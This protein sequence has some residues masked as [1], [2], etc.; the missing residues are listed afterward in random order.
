M[1]NNEN[2]TSSAAAPDNAGNANTPKKKEKK[3]KP[4]G[5]FKTMMASML[6]FILATVIMCVLFIVCTIGLL[7]HI[8]NE[9]TTKP[10]KITTES[11]LTLDLT[12]AISDRT[13]DELQSYFNNQEN[14]IGLCD[15]LLALDDAKNNNQI[16]GLFLYFGEGG[17]VNWSQSDEL[18]QSVRAFR[19]S[20]KPVVAYG[21]SYSQ[22]SYHLATAA[23]KIYL[24]PAGVIDLRGI[25]MESIYLKDLLEKYDIHVDLIRPNSNAFKSAGEMY[26]RNNMSDD[27]R[28]QNRAY[29]MRIWQIASDQMAN[30]RNMTGDSL[31]HIAANLEGFLANEAWQHGLVDS[32]EFER[33]ARQALSELCGTNKSTGI[34]SYISYYSRNLKPSVNKIALIYCEGDV[35]P[36]NE[37]PFYSGIYAN[38]TAKT[39]EKAADNN[40]VRA[41]VLRINTPGG[42]VTASEQIT[43]AVRYAKEKKPVIVSMGSMAAS[44]GYE[45]SSASSYI[46][47]QPFTITGSIG[48][49]G[50]AP[51]V[52]TLLS[53][54]LGITTD[55]V[56]TE[57][58]AA[59]FSIM[60]PMTP[61]A[62]FMM[63]R[64]VE[65][66]YETFCRRVAEG[67]SLDI[68]T[69]DSIGRGR[70]WCGADAV[71]IGLADTLGT[72]H[73]AIA[74][75]AEMAKVKD[76]ILIKFPE[77]KDMYTQ[78]YEYATQDR[79]EE[80]DMRIC[81]KIPHYRELL[82]WSK[83]QP[84]Q[85]RLPMMVY[86]L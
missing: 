80:I 42:A 23:D 72:L 68:E 17:S 36:G 79:N 67:R 40:S 15:I 8:I 4:M 51:E 35:M 14:S 64:N 7:I 26:T 53:K 65:D 78:L 12:T 47:A 22:P 28:E 81:Q 52:G 37:A 20:G 73:T 5:F 50:I 75:A 45:I 57:A 60:R 82:Y 84:L 25:A 55:T 16:K 21:N 43:D 3:K 69:V 18:R 24:N 39:I 27:A 13:P 48:V 11:Y 10:A 34:K 74:V 29:A 1:E 54:H 31:R 30:S 76:Y 19:D 66:F 6:G 33:S 32:L 38:T 83:A 49:F 86:D 63:Q 59:G 56:A 71:N 41:I 9:E 62:R 46:V 2:S 61:A 70:V 58:N 77:R 44:A 85:A